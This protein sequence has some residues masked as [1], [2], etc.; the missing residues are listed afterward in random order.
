MEA[1]MRGAREEPSNQNKMVTVTIT[2]Y[3]TGGN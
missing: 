3:V 2:I 1:K